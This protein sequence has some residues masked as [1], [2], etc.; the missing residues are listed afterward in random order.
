[1]NKDIKMSSK[2]HSSATQS[3]QDSFSQSDNQTR[4]KHEYRE[5]LINIAFAQSQTHIVFINTHGSVGD[6]DEYD[7]EDT[8]KCQP[9][10]T[11]FEILYRLIVSAPG[12]MSSFEDDVIFPSSINFDSKTL[13]PKQLAEDLIK[14]LETQ[15]GEDKYPIIYD[16]GLNF[17]FNSRYHKVIN[18]KESPYCHKTYMIEKEEIPYLEET[19]RKSDKHYSLGIF[20]LNG[21]KKRYNLLYDQQFIKWIKANFDYGF[22]LAFDRNKKQFLKSLTNEMLYDYFKEVLNINSLFVI[23]F[24]CESLADEKV[25][26]RLPDNEM[27]HDILALPLVDEIKGKIKWTEKIIEKFKME[28]KHL[29]DILDKLKNPQLK[30]STSSLNSKDELM[31]QLKT[32]DEKITT[33]LVG[34]NGD[35]REYNENIKTRRNLYSRLDKQEKRPGGFV[36]I[37]K[38]N[39]M[40]HKLQQLDNRTDSQNIHLQEINAIIKTLTSKLYKETKQID[41]RVRN[42]RKYQVHAKP[43][44][45]RWHIIKPGDDRFR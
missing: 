38:L 35:K 10:K 42:L 29:A 19:I 26:S 37:K 39:D 9:L 15:T 43:N 36:E 28:H 20:L 1:M 30:S 41:P 11:P 21:S 12:E 7:N 8:L 14:Y 18:F 24:S 27:K 2:P 34:N 13:T 16:R 31:K 25:I 22:K 23:D 4:K 45:K 32:I 44:M 17:G 5:K 3:Y 33:Y 6:D 40:K